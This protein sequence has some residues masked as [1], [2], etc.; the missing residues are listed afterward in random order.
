MKNENSIYDYLDYR[1]FL[2]DRIDHLRMTNESFSYRYFNMKSG[3]KSSGHLKQI[4]DGKLNLGKRSMY[5][6]CKGFGFSDKESRFFEK[7]VS[8]NQAKT[9]EEKEHF[10][11]KL[12]DCY[13]AKHPKIV[14][15]K[16][17]HVFA[18]WYYVA[19]M[20]IVRLETFK[21]DPKWIAK[22][23]KQD[24][25]VHVV[26]QAL[27]DLVHLGFLDRCSEGRL[28]P[29]NKM[30]TTPDEVESLAVIRYQ[31]QM[32]KLGCHAIAKDPVEK[33]ESSTLTIALSKDEFSE[34]KKKIQN[35]RDEIHTFLEGA[36]EE[37]K[38]CVAHLNLQL[39]QLTKGELS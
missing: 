12:L 7:L 24:V 37:T 17:Y 13:P 29:T 21:E 34:L 26:R 9:V 11:E 14:E 10:Y 38:E 6:V 28:K 16:H 20:E 36:S 2:K 15:A 22:K 1:E 33:K 30:I 4:I 3:M 23:L 19:M 31:Q 39:F 8:F 25:P 5:N 18:R 35:F 27:Q 32:T